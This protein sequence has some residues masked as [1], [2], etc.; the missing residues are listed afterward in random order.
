MSINLV[1]T[2]N[3]GYT[4][5]KQGKNAV[6]AHNDKAPDQYV[7]WSYDITDNK[8]NYCF[9]RYGSLKSAEKAFNKKEKGEYSG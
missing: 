5:I 9:G 3:A 2:I 1:G 8:A 6:I 7:A 4:I